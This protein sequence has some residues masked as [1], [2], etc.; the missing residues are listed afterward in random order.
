MSIKGLLTLLKGLGVNVFELL[1]VH[2]L[3]FVVGVASLTVSAGQRRVG[4]QLVSS[5]PVAT[6]IPTLVALFFSAA[7]GNATCVLAV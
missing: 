7:P 4:V 3:D 5:G 6:P 1:V 2:R